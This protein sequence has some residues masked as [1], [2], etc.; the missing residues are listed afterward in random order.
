MHASGISQIIVL[1]ILQK[2]GEEGWRLQISKI[3]QEYLRRRDLLLKAS[4]TYL[5]GLAEWNIPSAGMFLWYKL[6][7]VEDS[8]DLIKKEAVKEKILFVPGFFCYCFYLFLK[9]TFFFRKCILTHK[10]T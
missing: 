1:E 3:Y 8:N 10:R 9:N 6:L 2:W 4:E 7:N 5:K